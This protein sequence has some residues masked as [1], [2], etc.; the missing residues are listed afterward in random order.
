[1]I[2][3]VCVDLIGEA[4][5]IQES[6]WNMWDLPRRTVALER[7]DRGENVTLPRSESFLADLARLQQA[8]LNPVLIEAGYGDF[9]DE[10]VGTMQANADANENDDDGARRR[11]LHARDQGDRGQLQQQYA[12]PENASKKR[13]K[14][15]AAQKRKGFLKRV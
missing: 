6:L 7:K 11:A 2:E 8:A 10:E 9:G 15:K 5:D 13:S 12:V 1:M 14:N 4:S 3:E